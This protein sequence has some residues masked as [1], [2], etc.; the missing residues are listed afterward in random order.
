M[1]I[2]QIGKWYYIGASDRVNIPYDI[3][4]AHVLMYDRWWVRMWA[5]Q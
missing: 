1:Y 5:C 3:V 2:I 4:Y